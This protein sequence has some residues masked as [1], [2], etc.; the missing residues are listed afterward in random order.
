MM[1]PDEARRRWKHWLHA[2]DTAHG[3]QLAPDGDWRTWLFLGGRGAGKT[4]AGARWVTEQVLTG[5]MRRVA[6]VGPTL[7]DVRNVMVEGVSGLIAVAPEGFRPQYQPSRRRIVWGDFAEGFAFSAEDPDSLRGPQFDGAW[8]DELAAW[9]RLKASWDMLQ[10][11]LRLGRQPRAVVT[12]TPRPVPLLRQLVGA[13]DSAVTRA[14]TRANLAHL[15]PGFLESMEASYG[16]TRLAR[17]ELDGELLDGAAGHLWTEALLSEARRRGAAAMAADRIV[18][19]V[20]PP[21]GM[22]GDA[23]GIVAAGRSG[24][25]AI[26][27][28]DGTVSGASPLGWGRAVADL[29]AR[30][31]ADEIIA[32]ANQGGEMVRQVL[33]MAGVPAPVR[34]VHASR[35][36]RARAEPVA[37]LYEQGR[38]VHRAGLGA[39]EAELLGFGTTE[40]TGSPD[41][42]DALVWALWALMLEARGLPRIR[43]V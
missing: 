31:A 26:V 21:A 9:A 10:L 3:A 20:D 37:A 23:C 41:R 2:N 35:S 11:G 17:Q 15:A 28:A 36:K 38:V 6:L 40:M 32:E 5:R 39:L 22:A 7:S 16:G 18:V 30:L 24:D 43:V 19:A 1:T 4:W 42:V 12:T 27:L 8:C 34:L 33:E 13:G 25:L 29:A 14:G